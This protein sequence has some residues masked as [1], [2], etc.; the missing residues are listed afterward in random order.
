MRA[1]LFILIVGVIVIIAGLASG[2]I[3]LNQIREGR[4]PAVTATRNGV[5]AQGGQTPAFDVQTGSVKVGSSATT[6][7][8]PSLVVQKPSADQ[9]NATTNNAM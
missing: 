4:P 3:H 9:Q 5:T 2:F 6:V 1:I 7:K 8:V